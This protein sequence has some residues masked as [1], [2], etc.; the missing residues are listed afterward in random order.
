MPSIR[1]TGN[2]TIERTNAT[3]LNVE[4]LSFFGFVAGWPGLVFGLLFGL[5]V[6]CGDAGDGVIGGGGGRLEY[7]FAVNEAEVG[8]VV[9]AVEVEGDAYQ[10][11][12]FLGVG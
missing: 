6:G 2:T 12:F 11:A 1:P 7:V 5:G 10:G 3:M 4:G 9:C 8:Y